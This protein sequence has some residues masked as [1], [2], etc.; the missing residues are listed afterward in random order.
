[1]VSFPHEALLDLIRDR[2]GFV[3]DLLTG[4]L[5]VPVP[6]FAEVRLTESTLNQAAPVE[7]HADVAVLVVGGKPVLGVIVEAQLQKEARK[8]YTWPLYSVTARARHEC[9]FN[10]LVLTLDPQ[11]ARWASQPID[12]G[13]GNLFRPRVIGPDQVPKIIDADVARQDPQLAVLS[14]AAHGNGDPD[15]AVRIAL[16]AVDA[17]STLPEEQC[18]VYSDLIEAALS[19]A[20]RKVFMTLP[21]NQPF[22]SE[23]GRRSYERGVGEGEARGKV[24]GK[25]EGKAEALLKVL[26]L[27][28]LAI[29]DAQRS[30]ILE[31]AD[32]ATIDGW[33]DRALAVAS[34]D[35]LLG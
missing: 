21:Q 6:D 17:I 10:V 5:G 35:E 4:I 14:A 15:T 12:L 11:V 33:L 30:R 13:D 32:A 8:Q 27:R 29:T 34:V 1:M 18:R 22:Y 7:S 24:E 25:A 2:P 28:K 20:A 23:F 31:C 26:A 19:E 9:P 3:T 16:A